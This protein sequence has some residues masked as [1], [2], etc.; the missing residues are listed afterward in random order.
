[1]AA[2][3]A[4]LG[5]ELVEANAATLRYSRSRL[6][7]TWAALALLAVLVAALFWA[8]REGEQTN[9]EQTRDI[10]ELADDKAT[11]SQ[12]SS[13][14]VVSYLRGEQG[15]PGVPG[16]NG[17]N[18]S[19]GLPGS[20]ERGPAGEPGATGPQGAQGAPGAPS[21]ANPTTSVESG[22]AGVTGPQGAP[23]PRGEQGAAGPRGQA[24]EDGA[25]GAPGMPGP[26]GPPGPPFA[27][28]TSIAVGQSVSSPDTPKSAVATCLTGRASGGGFAVAPSD[29]GLVVTASSPVGNTGWNAT[30]EELSLPAGTAWQVFVFAICVS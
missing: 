11:K 26:A 9:D 10:A 30:V 13:D 16:S 27:P 6:L 8:W 19:P 17:V 18:G 24:G 15:I 29:P 5:D 21:S 7:A 3:P 23:G 28:S 12:E 14:D 25:A 1:M 20:G 4:E 22:P 2:R